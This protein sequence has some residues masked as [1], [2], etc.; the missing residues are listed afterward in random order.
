M[1]Q[2]SLQQNIHDIPQEIGELPKVQSAVEVYANKI[3]NIVLSDLSTSLLRCKPDLDKYSLS[4][5]QY[6]LL[7]KIEDTPGGITMTKIAQLL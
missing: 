5:A 1:T 2:E 7:Q 3:A 6:F 4:F